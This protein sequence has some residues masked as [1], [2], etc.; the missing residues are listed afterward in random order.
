M[1]ANLI[2]TAVTGIS[3]VA[4]GLA[5]GSWIT[6]RATAR[7]TTSEARGIDAKLPAEIDSVVVAGAE[8]AVLTMDKALQSANKRI[9]QLEAERE[10][11]RKRI[12]ALEQ[13]V[14]QFRGELRTAEE[15]L[16]A[17]RKTGELLTNQINTLMREQGKRK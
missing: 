15:H 4:V 5:G 7:K 3:A 12:A 16:T 10:A 9:D 2:G 1:D 11:D 8:A 17:A 14:A 6:G 13:Q